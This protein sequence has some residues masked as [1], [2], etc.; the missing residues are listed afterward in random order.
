[1]GIS[2]KIKPAKGPSIKY[3]T[4]FLV[5][6]YPPSPCHTSSHIQGPPESTSHISDP[7]ISRRPS[8]KNPDKNPLVQILFQLFAEVFVRVV[9][10][11]GLLSGRFC[12]GWL[13]SVPVLSE[14]I[15]Y[16][17]K[18]NITLNFMFRMYDKKFISVTSHALYRPPSVTN[19][20]TFS[21]PLPLERDV[22][23]G[24]LLNNINSSHFLSQVQL[25]SSGTW[26][27][28]EYSSFSIDSEGNNYTLR[29]SGFSGNATDSLTN[30]SM[31][32]AGYLDGMSFSNFNVDNDKSE[33]RNCAEDRGGGWWSKDC[34]YACLTCSY[35]GDFFRWASLWY[36]SS[37]G[38]SRLR[39]ARMMIKSK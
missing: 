3:V 19:C 4:L 14:Y 6:F 5:N 22:L 8:T 24:R 32:S 31:Q 18:L 27:Y 9:L 30:T 34:S 26:Y 21:D 29:L 25:N 38:A 20:H 1:M 36:L 2:D 23:Y 35:N 16:I 10:S 12:P 33:L 17:R 13:L 28:A 11:G 37:D 15:C 7:P 39:T